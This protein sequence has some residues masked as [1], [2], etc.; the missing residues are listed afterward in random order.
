MTKKTEWDKN[1]VTVNDIKQILA[2]ATL[3][4]LHPV[5]R[6]LLKHGISHTEFSELARKAYVDVAFKDFRIEGRKQTVSRVAV[7][8]GLSRKEVVRLQYIADTAPLAEKG[9]LNRA[10]R[11]ITGWTVDPEFRDA[12]GQPLPLPSIG[13][14]ASFATLIKRYS[15]DITAGAILDELVHVG[16]VELK[17]EL[18]FLRTQAY[19]PRNSELEKLKIMGICAADFLN[20][21]EHNVSTSDDDAR[22]QRAVI[23]PDLS[24]EVVDE[25]KVLSAEKANALLLELNQW[26][27]EKA[28]A[29][30][31]RPLFSARIK[32]G[33]GIYYFED[34]IVE[35]KKQ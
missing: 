12:Q 16:A 31:K 23:Y 2:A 35:D 34:N 4:I 33:L 20:T 10:A 6:V 14:G 24:R 29:T 9:P 17:D 8:T 18:L 1:P 25:F 32:T 5:V 26:L 21:I 3:K 15:G 19:V 11:V 28:R 7:L 22:F 27:A 13:D 30:A